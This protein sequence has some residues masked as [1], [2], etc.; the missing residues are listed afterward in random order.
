MI[1]QP[2]VCGQLDVKGGLYVLYVA[3]VFNLD[4]QWICEKSIINT[5]SIFK[6]KNH[7]IFMLWCISPLI[8]TIKM[9]YS[10]LLFLSMAHHI[11]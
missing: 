2:T 1:V 5:Y 8:N 3:L 7:D 6:K 11:I 9:F 10:L 4:A